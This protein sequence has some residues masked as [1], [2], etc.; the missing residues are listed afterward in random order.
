MDKKI[1]ELY[2]EIRNE[3]ERGTRSQRAVR[4]GSEIEAYNASID[5]S[6]TRQL[7]NA[8]HDTTVLPVATLYS[9]FTGDTSYLEKE[10]SDR[11]VDESGI[12]TYGG[13]IEAITNFAGTVGGGIL[14]SKG[15]RLLANKYLT[16]KLSKLSSKPIT[17]TIL[18]K[19]KR[20]PSELTPSDI[21]AAETYMAFVE[22]ADATVKENTSLDL[23]NQKVDIKEFDTLD[24]GKNVGTSLAL[25]SVFYLPF[26]V[27]SKATNALQNR[28]FSAKLANAGSA[29]F[30]TSAIQ[31]V[32]GKDIKPI[33]LIVRMALENK[34]Y[35]IVKKKD[36]SFQ[37]IK[38]GLNENLYYEK[39]DEDEA[40]KLV[41]KYNSVFIDE[42]T[43]K[44][45]SNIMPDRKSPFIFKGK[46]E[47]N[48][49]TL[50]IDTKTA[51]ITPEAI[52]KQVAGKPLFSLSDQN[53]KEPT[54]GSNRKIKKSLEAEYEILIDDAIKAFKEEGSI[55]DKAKRVA[56]KV[57]TSLGKGNDKKVKAIIRKRVF[58]EWRQNEG[59]N[60]SEEEKIKITI[61]DA[62]RDIKDVMVGQKSFI[63]GDEIPVTDSLD[64]TSIKEVKEKFF[65]ENREEVLDHFTERI[66]DLREDRIDEE[67]IKK[68]R[69]AIEKDLE[70]EDL[71]YLDI[72]K[73]ENTKKNSAGEIISDNEMSEP[74]HRKIA[75][76]NKL[77]Y[78]YDMYEDGKSFK[79]RIVP[80]M[81]KIDDFLFG[82][83]KKGMVKERTKLSEKIKDIEKKTKY[84]K[85]REKVKNTVLGILDVL[86]RYTKALYRHAGDKYQRK[87]STI[88]SGNFQKKGILGD[89]GNIKNK[90]IYSIEF[91]R[92]T[93]KNN[94]YGKRKYKTNSKYK[95]NMLLDEFMRLKN[96]PKDGFFRVT[97]LNVDDLKRK[98][99]KLKKEIEESKIAEKD[100]LKNL[101]EI[102][103]KNIDE[104]LAKKETVEKTL[105]S[106]KKYIEGIEA[107]NP[108]ENFRNMIIKR[109]IAE[110]GTF[111]SAYHNKIQQNIKELKDKLKNL[112]K[113]SDEFKKIEKKIKENENKLNKD[114]L[115]DKEFIKEFMKENKWLYK[116]K[117]KSLKELFIKEKEMIEKEIKKLKENLKNTAD[118]NEIEKEKIKEEIES[119]KNE[120]DGLIENMG[121]VNKIYS[122]YDEIL[123][124]IYTKEIVEKLEDI[125]RKYAEPEY[126]E[127]IKKYEKENETVRKY[128]EEYIEKNQLEDKAKIDEIF[129]NIQTKIYLGNNKNIVPNVKIEDIEI[130]D[131]MSAI[132]NAEIA[133]DTS[134]SIVKGILR[135]NRKL[136]DDA[137]DINLLR[138][139]VHELV[140]MS[141][142]FLKI[143]AKETNLDYDFDLFRQTIIEFL[144]SD[145]GSKYKKLFKINEP[146]FYLLN[147]EAKDELV[148]K[149]LE[150]IFSHEMLDHQKN[151]VLRNIYKSKANK[152][153]LKDFYNFINN[154]LI[155]EERKKFKFVLNEYKRSIFNAIN[156]DAT[157]KLAIQKKFTNRFKEYATGNSYLDP[158]IEHEV[159]QNMSEYVDNI[160]L[161]EIFKIDEQKQAIEKIASMHKGFEDQ[162]IKQVS[163]SKDWFTKKI[164]DGLSV[165]NK[166]ILDYHL[167]RAMY[168]GMHR[169]DN[170]LEFLKGEI[171][172]RKRT[173]WKKFFINVKD[174]VEEV[175]DALALED[176]SNRNKIRKHLYRKIEKLKGDIALKKEINE[177]KLANDLI[178]ERG[179]LISNMDLK[180][181][182]YNTIN[183][184]KPKIEKKLGEILAKKRIEYFLKNNSKEFLDTH[185]KA[186]ENNIDNFNEAVK[187]WK[188]HETILKREGQYE[189]LFGFNPD[190]K[191]E[192]LDRKIYL[193]QHKPKS[194]KYRTLKT[195][196][197]DKYT[198]MYMVLADEPN[199][200][201]GDQDP[202][203]VEFSPKNFE[204]GI[205]NAKVFAKVYKDP[206]RGWYI[207][208]K[209]NYKAYIGKDSNFKVITKKNHSELLYKLSADEMFNLKLNG[210]HDDFADIRIS[211]MYQRNIYLY[212][213]HSL[214]RNFR[215]Y[216]MKILQDAKVVINKLDYEELSPELQEKYIAFKTKDYG[217]LYVQRRFKHQLLGSKGF[218]FKVMTK[219]L[220]NLPELKYFIEAKVLRSLIGIAK[221]IKGVTI[222]YNLA[223]Y[224]NSSISSYITYALAS[225]NPQE[226]ISNIKKARRLIDQ[227]KKDMT[228]LTKIKNEIMAKEVDGLEVSDV[229]KKYNE[230]LEKIK[231]NPLHDA[232]NNGLAS[233][234][235]QDALKVNAYKE[236]ELFKTIRPLFRDKQ[237]YEFMKIWFGLP[238]TKL[239]MKLGEYFDNTEM[240]PKLAL[241]IDG[242]NSGLNRTTAA[243]KVIMHFPNYG[244]NLHPVISG[245]ELISPYMKY[246]VNY[247]K[248]IYMFS[249]NKPKATLVVSLTA[250]F[251]PG[252]TYSENLNKR[253]EW[254]KDNHFI[255]LGDETYYYIGSWFPTMPPITSGN[256]NTSVVL[257]EDA[258]FRLVFPFDLWPFVH[259]K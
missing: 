69:E 129:D 186:L 174:D 9:A 117:N 31:K 179:R 245:F 50:V 8:I 204:K 108:S 169:I 63:D 167:G 85:G 36:G 101:I 136:I 16:D 79:Y 201:V 160:G 200:K 143:K 190:L 41:D 68:I 81:E 223:S 73:E 123:E 184:D 130:V 202:I 228:E 210:L 217:T 118:E 80:N 21:M 102:T 34:G 256:F 104:N 75:K 37:E 107:N 154:S 188:I 243:Q 246:A 131:T 159:F 70:A 25:A 199:V 58:N 4:R 198:R 109:K 226:F 93:N 103:I 254:F 66:E 230:I 124:N 175:L 47:D 35:A 155:E 153:L 100:E 106:F 165:E 132:Q 238:D 171:N 30:D 3:L 14:L 249:R 234:L 182:W 78:A 138:G 127:V 2:N 53:Y 20:K 120:K 255:K 24:L 185:L 241:Y 208:N 220:K 224:I 222:N 257:S 72:V 134:S 207:K 122:K 49:N 173:N 139:I 126:E 13:S 45:I 135:I 94:F 5:D 163:S 219:P 44:I 227:Y 250:L 221:I 170:A 6:I 216:Q 61:S 239:G 128:I 95:T 133:I 112:K 189:Q 259:T 150:V 60:F 38:K 115:E 158:L 183:K 145:Q 162:L 15:T 43:N 83:K 214:A 252:I 33:D 141:D 84:I 196:K 149:F 187:N 64:D 48:G 232:F 215:A 180:I 178:K 96:K 87:S 113:D 119:L 46:I 27:Y 161:L 213:S 11:K 90:R 62:L 98:L 181:E 54:V 86:D 23:E 192:N 89:I 137:E 247:P 18:G 152:K 52:R 29:K 233:T 211:T 76:R 237:A 193:M 140:H 7:R 151:V 212:K 168:N 121:E 82:E 19:A 39:I 236:N 164:F 177:I 157:I 147:N 194:S 240:L 71:Q 51:K 57:A 148:P 209:N 111:V 74:T 56:D 251:A 116:Y 235:R 176:T 55:I 253:E 97:Y 172:T 218:N 248:M 91:S 195:I 244:I 1:T 258:L 28:V 142:E 203:I 12:P 125:K 110:D 197:L 242:L 206:K 32:T 166:N 65:K 67:G 144:E 231:D 114:P 92:G 205:Y 40:N 77:K 17:T 22:G 26:T 225:N 191:F 105:E 229:T 99:E 156:S 10:F 146:R 59:T 42:E 88:L